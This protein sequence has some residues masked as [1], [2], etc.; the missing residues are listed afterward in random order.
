MN[1]VEI[2]K[3][4]SPALGVSPDISKFAVDLIA[5]WHYD[6]AVHAET[7]SD[8]LRHLLLSDKLYMIG[9]MGTRGVQND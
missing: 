3:P 8:R 5:S 1:K 9:H 4:A 2:N 7:D 6:K